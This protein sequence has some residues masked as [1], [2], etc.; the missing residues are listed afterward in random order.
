MVFHTFSF[1]LS[2]TSYLKGSFWVMSIW[3]WN[4]T[5]G[6]FLRALSQSNVIRY[7]NGFSPYRGEALSKQTWW[8]VGITGTACE[9]QRRFLCSK[10]SP[11]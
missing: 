6:K 10:L 1:T 9:R 4:R 3:G 11:S 8:P 5:N 7:M 2:A